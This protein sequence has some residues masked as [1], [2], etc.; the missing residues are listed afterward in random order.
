MIRILFVFICALCVLLCLQEQTRTA[1]FIIP[2]LRGCNS[3]LFDQ[4]DEPKISKVTASTTVTT[5]AEDAFPGGDC[6]C[7]LPLN[8][9]FKAQ[10]GQDQYL[11]QRIFFPQGDLCCR[12][13]FRMEGFTV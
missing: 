3:Y 12:G 2:V 4:T 6:G 11:F 13:V 8:N 7:Y 5:P 10:S 1:D 9:E